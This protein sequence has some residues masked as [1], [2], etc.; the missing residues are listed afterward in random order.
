[1]PDFKNIKKVVKNN[2]KVGEYGTA[3]GKPRKT[4]MRPNNLVKFQKFMISIKILKNSAEDLLT[5]A[6]KIQMATRINY[7]HE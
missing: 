2:T 1:V 3:L 7:Q 6:P 5:A 4:N